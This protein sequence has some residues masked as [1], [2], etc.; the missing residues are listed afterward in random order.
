MDEAGVKVLGY[1]TK[2]RKEWMKQDTWTNISGRKETK[3][4]FNA[5]RSQ[6]LKDRQ[7]RIYAELNREVKKMAKADKKSFMEGLAE[8]AEEAARKQDLKT[9]CRITKTLNNDV[10][11]NHTNGNLVSSETGQLES[12]KEHFHIEQ[13]GANRDSSDT[14][15]L[16]C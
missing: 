4:K 9:H 1:K 3:Q 14:R 11:V 8:G 5:T 6:R 16:R 2:K 12:W 10:R 15:Q 7:K 13:A